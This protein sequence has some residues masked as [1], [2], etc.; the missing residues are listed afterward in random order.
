MRRPHVDR[1]DDDAQGH[2]DG[3]I[4]GTFSTHSLHLHYVEQVIGRRAGVCKTSVRHEC[5]NAADS[6]PYLF[7]THVNPRVPPGTNCRADDSGC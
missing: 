1:R 7:V 5:V 4:Y 3:M 6:H 2:A